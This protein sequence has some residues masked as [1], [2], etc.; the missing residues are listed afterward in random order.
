M[1]IQTIP[2][3]A[4][5]NIELGL[6]NPLGIRFA[7]YAGQNLIGTT[8]IDILKLRNDYFNPQLTASPPSN[9]TFSGVAGQS[10][11]FLRLQ[12][13][14]N[15][16]A[17]I[18]SP[19]SPDNYRDASTRSNSTTTTANDYLYLRAISYSTYSSITISAT[20]NY[21]YS[22]SFWRDATGVTIIASNPQSMTVSQ[23]TGA[24]YSTWEAHFS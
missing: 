10:Y 20:A 17:S 23:F 19:T 16:F 15:G 11:R 12:T 4:T 8:N 9:Y 14:G 21:G 5:G 3:T 22:F 7:G 18:T 13:K 6:S 1:S 24:Q 2:S